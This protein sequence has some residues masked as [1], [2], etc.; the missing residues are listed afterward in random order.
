MPAA[1][2]ISV[3]DA[4]KELAELLNR[5][6]YAKDRI[7]VTRRGKA[8]AAIVP[9]DDLLELEHLDQV[10]E[11]HAESILADEDPAERVS[12]DDLRQEL[13]NEPPLAAAGK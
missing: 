9:V 1:F 13:D 2:E 4:R 5:A 11:A 3:S 6:S 7:V 12:L 10:D 8:I